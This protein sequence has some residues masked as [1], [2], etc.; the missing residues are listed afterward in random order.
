M[1]GREWLGVLAG[2]VIVLAIIGILRGNAG[3]ADCDHKWRTGWAYAMVCEAPDCPQSNPP[4]MSVRLEW[5]E[6]CGLIRMP[7]ARRK[8]GRDVRELHNE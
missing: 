1:K 3:G 6:R 4:T 8:M 5:C 7:E 2:V